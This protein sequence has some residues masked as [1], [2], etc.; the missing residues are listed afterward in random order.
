[1]DVDSQKWLDFATISRGWRRFFY[2]MEGRRLRRLEQALPAWTKGVALVTNVEVDLFRS[3]CLPGQ[4]DA[5]PNGV[6]L[7]YFRPQ[8]IRK[9]SGC[10]FVGALDYFP[11]VDAACWFVSEIWP[12]IR[13]RRP[14]E[15]LRLV[16][17]K[18]IPAVSRLGNVPGVEVLG[19]VP[20]VRP[21]IAEAA[22]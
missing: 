6:N 20:D 2:R 21:Y 9:D 10:V 13:E 5:I 18:P 14:Q 16:G 17:R 7:E 12:K 3:F 19:M 15:R 11:N 4:V 1:V 8:E 22:V